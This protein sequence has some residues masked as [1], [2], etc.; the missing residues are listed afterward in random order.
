MNLDH[1]L[2]NIADN[3]MFERLSKSHDSLVIIKFIVSSVQTLN[4]YSFLFIFR[5]SYEIPQNVF[6]L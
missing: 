3:E 5:L 4:L 1:L 6:S 2:K